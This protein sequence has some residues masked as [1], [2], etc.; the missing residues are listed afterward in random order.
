[1]QRMAV[2]SDIHGN[3]LALQAVVTDMQK[4]SVESVINLGD[5]LS[6]PLWPVETADFLMQ[7]DWLQIRGNH[8]RQLLEQDPAKHNATDRYTYER[9]HEGHINWLRSLPASIELD[10]GIL[11]VHGAPG[12]DMC[13][14]LETIANDRTHLSSAAEIREKLNGVNAS[15]VLCGHTHYQRVVA[16]E[17]MLIVNPGSVG[18]Q[19]YE[20]DAPEYHAIEA[21]SP[22]ARYA[23]LEKKQDQWQVEL[24]CVNYD[25]EQAVQQARKN[26]R[27]DWEIALKTGYMNH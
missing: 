1:M 5:H 7:Q 11:A 3:F 24:I 22:H 21:A 10:E 9:L 15:L 20:D 17:D 6:G 14:L 18:L 4:R 19:A 25:V 27:P 12:D 2:L 16:L 13:Y 23:L 26:N 8:E